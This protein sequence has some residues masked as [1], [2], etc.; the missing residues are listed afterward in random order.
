M[1]LAV[2]GYYVNHRGK[3]YFIRAEISCDTDRVSEPLKLGLCIQPKTGDPSRFKIFD[4]WEMY[5]YLTTG[6]VKACETFGIPFVRRRRVQI[7]VRAELQETQN[8]G[9]LCVRAYEPKVY[10]SL[11]EVHFLVTG[12]HDLGISRVVAIGYLQWYSMLNAVIMH[13]RKVRQEQLISDAML[14]SVFEEFQSEDAERELRIA[15]DI[16]SD[17]DAFIAEVA[18]QLDIESATIPEEVDWLECHEFRRIYTLPVEDVDNVTGTFD[19]R[20]GFFF[21]TGFIY[22]TIYN[23]SLKYETVYSEVRGLAMIQ[24]LVSKVQADIDLRLVRTSEYG[25]IREGCELVTGLRSYVDLQP[26]RLV[27]ASGI[28]L[29]ELGILERV[30]SWFQLPPDLAVMLSY[31]LNGDGFDYHDLKPD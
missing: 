10:A 22:D 27:H 7:Y 25:N 21:D 15:G 11:L 5:H 6:F 28:L 13:A 30:V 18:L 29:R 4:F 20:E 23:L 19:D 1:T 12:E 14:E 17:V 2:Y 26:S 24:Q 3:V 8:M 9:S 31:L 16:S